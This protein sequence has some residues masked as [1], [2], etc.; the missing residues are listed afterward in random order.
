MRGLLLTACLLPHVGGTAFAQDGSTAP[1]RLEQLEKTIADKKRAQQELTETSE[2]RRQEA[3]ELRR[4]LVA[5]AQSLQDQER[6]ASELE[7]RLA[8]LEAEEVLISNRLAEG[9]Q[10]LATVLAALQDMELSRPP[11]LAVAPEDAAHAARIALLLSAAAP[12]LQARA[13][14]LRQDLDRLAAVR[15][16]AI[17]EKTALEEAEEELRGRQFVLEDLILQKRRDQ[18]AADA[19]LQRTQDEIAQLAAQATSLRDLVRRLE[20]RARSLAPRVKPGGPKPRRGRG[21]DD[22]RDLP[23]VASRGF[24][25][26]LRFADA[27]GLLRP[28]VAGELVR[29]FGDRFR[30]G[31]SEGI[32]LSARRRGVVTAP[33][34]A[35]VVFARAKKPIGNVL[36]LD[37]GG[38]YLMILVGVDQFLCVESQSVLAGEPIG[39]MGRRRQGGAEPELY[40]E[41]R[42][43]SEPVDPALWLATGGDSRARG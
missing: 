32:A 31:R 1:E 6:R 35:E 40:V 30:G 5:A 11:A 8:A 14:A 37:V 23:P 22:R 7:T 15:T 38:G 18:E 19:A 17:A 33:F 4:K 24:T 36:I 34:D 16:A 28:P 29:G 41:I 3:D 25:P 26:E 21:R 39:L 20:N 13:E 10:S 27:Q 2:K 43:D 42:K 12:E 9:R